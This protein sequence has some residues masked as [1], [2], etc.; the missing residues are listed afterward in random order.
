MSELRWLLRAKRWAQ[1]PPSAGRVKLVFAVIALCLALYG[2]EKT[3][4]L[5]DWMKVE[6]ST[7]VKPKHV[8]P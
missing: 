4:G 3:I 5:P 8:S 1:N 7:R 2:V 6:G